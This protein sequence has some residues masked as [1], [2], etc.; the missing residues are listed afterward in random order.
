MSSPK[1]IAFG[2]L[3][4]TLSALLITYLVYSAYTHDQFDVLWQGGVNPTRYLA[5]LA[6]S[7]L[8]L[9]ITFVRWYFLVYG[10]GLPIRI[11]DAIRF[12]FVGYFFNFVTVGTVGGD[13][14]RAF[15]VARNNPDRRTEA[16]ATVVV[17]RLIGLVALFTLTGIVLMCL[18]LNRLCGDDLTTLSVLE[19]C[20]W[21]S[22]SC[23]AA[24]LSLLAILCF[25]R[26]FFDWKIWSKL[27][28]L[29]WVGPITRQLHMAGVTYSR[30][31]S[32]VFGAYL[33]S[34]PVHAINSIAVFVVATSLPIAHPSLLMHLVAVPLSSL[35]G[36]L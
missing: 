6:L 4:I 17:D 14:L 2:I 20:R 24:G 31:P 35:A 27:F 21:V 3:K 19:T 11:W 5:A 36:V 28:E 15:F 26:A 22:V 10:L 1:K 25:F 13:A 8:A 34:L 16:I 7:L 12:G 32:I 29:R 18:D 23:G 30:R 9:L 33:A